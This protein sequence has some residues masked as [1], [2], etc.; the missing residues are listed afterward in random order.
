MTSDAHP[1]DHLVYATRDLAESVAALEALLGARFA[2][3]GSHHD[4][5][6]RNAILPLGASSYLEVIGPD[7]D[8]GAAVA[9]APFGIASAAAPRLATWSAKGTDLARL[10]ERARSRGVDLGATRRG[11]R[12]R[13]DG[14]LL[15]W[16]MT[17]PLAPRCGG[18][19]PFFIDWGSTE[20]PARAARSEPSATGTE[21][22][23]E[24]LD[25]RARHP[26]PERVAAFLAAL[27]VHLVVE[28]GAE[29]ALAATL[30]AP[31]GTVVLV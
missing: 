9:V 3:G 8:V 18:V 22:R 29:P 12:F 23:I 14:S 16:E 31:T 5:G 30:R 20:H 10:A 27:G 6:T 17:E 19:I 24:L 4:W 11:S 7:P 28:R 26:E 1:L 25:L 21:A 2:P 13:P 15:S